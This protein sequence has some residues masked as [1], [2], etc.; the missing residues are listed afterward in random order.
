MSKKCGVCGETVSSNVIECPK[1][2]RGVFES[3]KLHRDSVDTIRGVSSTAESHTGKRRKHLPFWKRLFEAISSKV[4]DK[5]AASDNPGDKLYIGMSFDEIVLLLGKPS[6]INPGTEMLKV[7]PSSIVVASE[8]T[9]A[10][11]ARTQYCMWKRPEGEYLLTIEDG[12]LANIYAKPETPTDLRLV[13]AL[14]RAVQEKFK[15]NPP[16]MVAAVLL[17]MTDKN[18]KDLVERPEGIY[19]SRQCWDRI[20]SYVAWLADD[21]VIIIT[22][23]PREGQPD[24][25]KE[26][27]Q[28]FLNERLP[29]ARKLGGINSLHYALGLTRTFGLDSNRLRVK[30][31]GTGVAIY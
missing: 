1:C 17:A 18:R 13:M 24:E 10:Q 11:L 5:S 9:R 31:D 28:R 14:S 29:K 6:G 30:N 2:G 20:S 21:G 25:P 26:D 12:K 7:G 27:S 8:E 22:R 3:E 16:E 15:D 19:L 4:M 23:R